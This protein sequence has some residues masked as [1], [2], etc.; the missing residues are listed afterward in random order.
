MFNTSGINQETVNSQTF[1]D[2]PATS[3]NIDKTN[4]W[5]QARSD[6]DVPPS[7]QLGRTCGL[8]IPLLG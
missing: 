5:L 8:E 4:G 3:N 1:E 7:I 6:A 2:L